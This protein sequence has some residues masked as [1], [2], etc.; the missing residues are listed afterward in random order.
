MKFLFILSGIFLLSLLA[1]AE[2]YS[3]PR[4]SNFQRTGAYAP[5]RVEAKLLIPVRSDAQTLHFIRDNNDPRVI[6]KSYLLK[7][8]E[9]YEI[10]DCIRMMV[11]SK[12]VGNTA[13]QQIYP[14]NT[15]P[16]P[17][18]GNTATLSSAQPI[19]PTDQPTYTV[20]AQL[21][22]NTAVECI[23][24]AD[25]IGLL[26]ISAEEY[27]FADTPDGMGFDSIVK[28]LD[29]PQM[30]DLTGTQIFFY[31]P[32]YVPAV[33]LQPLI[34]NVGMNVPSDVTELWQGSD[35]VTY[36]P[37]LNL[38]IFDTANYSMPIVEKMLQ[39]YDQ[40]I[41]QVRLKISVYE[42]SNEN[43]E[44]M[45][46]DFQAWKNNGGMDFFSGGGRFRNNW[47]ALYS[48]GMG[49]TGSE[50]TGFYNFNP[51]WNTRYLD[52]LVAKGKGKIFHSAEVL[53]RNNTPATVSNK[54]S[55]FYFSAP[56]PE[57]EAKLIS[58]FSALANKV[59]SKDQDIPVW[60]A[61][62]QQSVVQ[63]DFGFTMS[64]LNASVTSE[65]VNFTVTLQ[66]SSLI[67]FDSNG[68]PRFSESSL[69]ELNI[70]LPQGKNS[71]VIGGLRKK[72]IVKSSSGIPFLKD[73]PLLG[74]L[75]STQSETVKESHLVVTGECTM[76]MPQISTTP[77]RRSK[78]D[79]N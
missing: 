26:I 21:G 27:R 29:R 20:P 25:G 32:K 50:R 44:K 78:S 16:S 53:I 46:A 24:Y 42:F 74:L 1:G 39:Q 41:P 60:K 35:A 9:A 4:D 37:D 45:G 52:F 67:G 51:K 23:K 76:E 38:L 31:F 36:D 69:K 48:G 18:P 73:I 55:L 66:N 65:A 43:D 34:Q 70:T 6:T 12:R 71:F 54:Q 79:Q 7:H 59:I 77:H 75:F 56:V 3:A 14:G 30:G 49:N 40:P 13:L 47:S 57:D 33:N 68:V 11:Q 5:T 15:T 64:I 22:S 19:P 2:T 10:R 63:S 8:A 61:P 28:F 62:A 17:A 58:F 72:S